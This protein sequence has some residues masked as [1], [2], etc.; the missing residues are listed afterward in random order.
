MAAFGLKTG[1]GLCHHPELVN[2]RGC[3]HLTA[4]A[5]RQRTDPHPDMRWTAS[6]GAAALLKRTLTPGGVRR[7]TILSSLT[8]A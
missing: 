3:Q 5:S 4:E 8:I 6:A 7:Q 1:T 2:V